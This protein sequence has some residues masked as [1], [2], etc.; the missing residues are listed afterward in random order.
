MGNEIQISLDRL[1]YEFGK[2]GINKMAQDSV[3]AQEKNTLLAHLKQ[4]NTGKLILQRKM[5]STLNVSGTGGKNK[6]VKIEFRKK[7]TLLKNQSKEM[8]PT[9]LLEPVK[10]KNQRELKAAEIK[11][12]VEE[13]IHR[14]LE[15]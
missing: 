2:S 11:R 3:T 10:E 14:K 7:R 12:K 4:V 8:N 6:S 9:V 5:R 13:E 1:I 15:E